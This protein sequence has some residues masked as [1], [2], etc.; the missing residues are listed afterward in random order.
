VSGKDP[1][2][3]LLLFFGILTIFLS[4]SPTVLNEG[5]IYFLPPPLYPG[6]EPINYFV[7]ISLSVCFFILLFYLIIASYE[8]YNISLRRIFI[9]NILVIL[10]DVIHIWLNYPLN[11]WII[12]PSGLILISPF[13]ASSLYKAVL[14]PEYEIM[15]EYSY[16]NKDSLNRIR[17]RDKEVLD[18]AKRYGGVITKSVLVHELQITLEEASRSLDRFLRHGEAE[19]KNID[20]L[21]VYDF[22]GARIYLSNSDI[23]IVEILRDLPNGMLRV[24]LLQATSFSIEALE[25][26]IKRLES[27]GIV[28]YD[29][30]SDN[31]KLRGIIMK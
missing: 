5:H 4:I 26:S 21:T 10:I 3:A 15:N 19:R 2:R 7:E 18:T 8:D 30:I 23:K 1:A 24:E 17:I 16:E 27:K 9:T 25:E 20:S 29:E 6:D 13:F 28:Y 11:I 14:H 12:I 22:P 31:Y